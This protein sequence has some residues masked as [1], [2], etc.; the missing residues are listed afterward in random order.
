MRDDAGVDESASLRLTVALSAAEVEV[1][2]ELHLQADPWAAI[3]VA[4]GAGTRM[5]N[6]FLVGFAGACASLGLAALR[7]NFPY[8]EAG[9]R[10]PG[11]ASHAIVTW[12]AV[13]EFLRDQIQGI[14]I[15]ACGRSYG[16]RMAS[17]AAAEGGIAPDAL[18][19]LGYPLHPPDR[20]ENPR[21]EHL[22]AIAAPQLF[23]S[24]ETDPFVAPHE[25]LTDA[26]A[27]CQDATLEWVPG[28]HSFVV[29]GAKQPAVEIGAGLAARTVAFLRARLDAWAST[30]DRGTNGR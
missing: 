21:V 22:P 29:K 13:D 8:S 16:G 27:A 3:G 9:R 18:V 6:P 12:A 11:P 25:Q 7:F 26:V 5:D 17:M 20:P 23:L 2:A 28:D 10:V 14:P 19:Y 30:P 24:G 4:H 1:S 15:V